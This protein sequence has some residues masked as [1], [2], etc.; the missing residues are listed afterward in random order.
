MYALRQTWKDIFP[1]SKLHLLDITIQR[2]DPK[3]PVVS[4]PQQ[5][6]PAI[7]VNPNFFKTALTV[8]T[9]KK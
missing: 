9:K 6:Q 1:Q 7:H 3:W 8:N 2:I 4:K 5:Q